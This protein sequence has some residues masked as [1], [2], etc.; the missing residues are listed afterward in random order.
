MC[1]SRP[2]LP[3]GLALLVHQPGA[4]ISLRPARV[5]G[6]RFGCCS[7]S[8]SA[9]LQ[10]KYARRPVV[11]VALAALLHPRPPQIAAGRP[12]RRPPAQKRPRPKMKVLQMA[13]RA[14]MEPGT[15]PMLSRARLCRGRNLVGGSEPA[16]TLLR[17]RPFHG[18]KQRHSN[19][20]E[21]RR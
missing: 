1:H 4:L 9:L 21:A 13:L 2:S 20:R 18:H 8:H 7:S 12:G 3:V 5:R 15:P 16:T 17:A 11:V 6:E 14:T 19:S 10:E